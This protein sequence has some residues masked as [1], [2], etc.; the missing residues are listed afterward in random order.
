MS[1]R[2]ID[3]PNHSSA[4]TFSH[5][6]AQ[7]ARLTPDLPAYTFLAEGEEEEA[8][9]T[10]RQL[11]LRAQ[12]VGALLAAAG[13]RGERVLLLYPPGLDYVAAFFACLWCGATAVPAYPPR[14]GRNL[15][16][17]LGIAADSSAALA[18]TTPELLRR[19]GSAIAAAP[20]LAGM[21][22]L[23]PEIAAAE[24]ARAPDGGAAELAD[25]ADGLAF[26]QYTSG[27]TGT[28]RGVMVR[29]RDLLANSEA[30][31]RA[32]GQSAASV[33]VGWLPLYHDMGLIG[34]LLQPLYAG[35]HCILMAPMAFLQ[36]P[37]RWLRAI[38]RYR[39]T[40][41]G[42]PD[43]A[44]ALCARQVP[45]E[46]CRGL[47][48]S[49]WSVAFCGAEPVREA[50]LRRFADA[51]A[52]YGFLPQALRP[53]YGLAESTLLVSAAHDGPPARL[54]LAAAGI[55]QHRVAPPAPGE[56]GR[57]LV[58][59]GEPAAATEVLVVEP[60]TR[61]PAAP[62]RIGEVWVRGASVAAGYWGRPEETAATFGAHLAGGPAGAP[63]LR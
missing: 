60:A 45:P 37:V 15:D 56:P 31:R 22:W 55:E 39:A 59:C 29:H 14:Q 18:L 16:R 25:Q 49:T 11:A 19:M 43:F 62:D 61:L 36:R 27:S 1:S 28:P 3:L 54:T 40:T 24:S 41:S 53:C 48:L 33:V 32:F 50:T 38:S 26:L 10:Y 21:R 2:E 42:G 46:A 5:L 47:D 34:N 44:Y 63:Y 57:T 6:L 51:F 13:A 30:I 23:A 12:A 4:A 7:R 9:L 20:G 52:P 8:R 35:C 17:L 58:G